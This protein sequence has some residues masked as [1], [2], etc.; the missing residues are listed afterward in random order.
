MLLVSTDAA[1]LVIFVAVVQNINMWK[2]KSQQGGV[3]RRRLEIRLGEGMPDTLLA[4]TVRHLASPTLEHLT[5][6]IR[7]R[8]LQGDVIATV[9]SQCSKSSSTGQSLLKHLEIYRKD[10]DWDAQDTRL[11]W[12][13]YDDECLAKAI[14]NNCK[15]SLQSFTLT[16][17]H[18]T[19]PIV[20]I[21]QALTNLPQLSA[22]KMSVYQSEED[23]APSAAAAAT[24]AMLDHGFSLGTL[25]S[26]LNKPEPVPLRS[27]RL[28]GVLAETPEYCQVLHDAYWQ[29]KCQ[30]HIFLVFAGTRRPGVFPYYIR[31]VMELNQEGRWEIGPGDHDKLLGLLHHV[32]RQGRTHNN[33]GG[34]NSSSH[35]KTGPSRGS[36]LRVDDDACSMNGNDALSFETDG[37]YHL[38]RENPWIFDRASASGKNGTRSSRF[39]RRTGLG[40]RKKSVV[41]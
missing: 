25:K 11:F 29:S 33:Q 35:K 17:F 3:G 30:V 15:D 14:Q 28:L 41:R 2:R 16:D 39:W 9:L 23:N 31:Q 40:R 20:A 6:W 37:L 34:S 19:S 18:R 24:T 10:N 5:I 21:S 27:L 8:R 12:T 7:G 36:A 26:L 1:C 32:I 38:L 4:S 13:D 22:V